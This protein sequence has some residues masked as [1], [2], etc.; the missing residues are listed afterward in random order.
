MS[1]VGRTF[2][3]VLVP[4]LFS[5]LET[6]LYE[7]FLKFL[8]SNLIDFEVAWKGCGWKGADSEKQMKRSAKEKVIKL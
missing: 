6:A 4:K 8:S 5:Q 7:L 2:L 3:A 1:A